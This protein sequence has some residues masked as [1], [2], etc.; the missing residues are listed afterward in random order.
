MTEEMEKQLPCD[1]VNFTPP[2]L[3]DTMIQQTPSKKS[4]LF[5]SRNHRPVWLTCLLLIFFT[6]AL[7]LGL[8]SVA[9]TQLFK[10][11]NFAYKE[12]LDLRRIISSTI[13]S[14]P[15]T[16]C[17]FLYEKSLSK[18]Y[19]DDSLFA[20]V[21]IFSN[22]N[23]GRHSM[24][25]I[26]RATSNLT[27][28]AEELLTA[29]LNTPV[30]VTSTVSIPPVSTHATSATTETQ[31]PHATSQMSPP[32]S[33]APVSVTS[34]AVNILTSKPSSTISSESVAASQVL[35]TSTGGSPDDDIPTSTKKGSSPSV[36]RTVSTRE[37]IYT[38]TLPNG[39]LSTSTSTTIVQVE[40]EESSP[41]GATK[42]KTPAGLQT[43]IAQW[44]KFIPLKSK[45]IGVI[46]IMGVIFW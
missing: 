20:D 29:P 6:L 24:E 26:K 42:T 38:T 31:T 27:G 11:P 23:A 18:R 16:P 17:K 41:T 15:N 43:N 2:K 40:T 22:L 28:V 19:H 4:R 10:F 5:R 8:A 33:N 21:N 3:K 30:T 39:A 34:S 13:S 14:T 12:I 7:S 44:T 9:S 45:A 36:V 32:A 37:T 25:M 46:S 35:I 1:R